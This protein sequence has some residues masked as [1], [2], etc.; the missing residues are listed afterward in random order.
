MSTDRS[1]DLPEAGDPTKR[2]P[3]ERLDPTNPDSAAMAPGDPRDGAGD[4]DE[5]G[6]D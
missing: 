1:E 6:E 2:P 4:R 5:E 3:E